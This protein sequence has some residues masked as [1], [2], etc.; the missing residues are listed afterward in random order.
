MKIKAF[1][2]AAVGFLLA[3]S[4]NLV[5]PFVIAYS[6]GHDAVN[7]MFNEYGEKHVEAV[8]FPL[9]FMAGIITFIRLIN[10]YRKQG[11]RAK[12]EDPDD[13]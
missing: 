3:L 4:V 1:D 8:L 2:C 12:K 6:S 13:H 5:I 11:R 9:W 7:L 10:I